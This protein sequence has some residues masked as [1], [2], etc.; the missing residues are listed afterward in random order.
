MNDQVI[1]GVT[2]DL[3]ANATAEQPESKPAEDIK[4]DAEQ[5]SGESET[6]ENN[7]NAEEELSE[8]DK[9]KQAFEKRIARQTA[10]NRDLN[11]RYSDAIKRI[12]EF[13]A[14]FQETET[15]KEPSES[16]FETYEEFVQAKADWT[17]ERKFADMQK[18]EQQRIAQE[19]QHQALE[20]Q[21]RDFEAKEA[22]F[23]ADVSDYDVVSQEFNEIIGSYDPETPALQAASA[24][25][26]GADNTPALGYHLAKN[27]HEIDRILSMDPNK[28]YREVVKLEMK[29]A[30]QSKAPEPTKLPNPPSP[31]DGSGKG[32]KPLHKKSANE[33]VDWVNS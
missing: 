7:E 23:R 31:V 17:A 22:E 14:K 19:K 12:E 2:P 13:E 29:L 20:S 9:V 10:A 3:E 11:T 8:T 30:N 6:N 1:E 21:R 33:L 24:A 5:V 25:L 26:M 28:A 15:A 16:D 18:Q 4:E 32:S 27:P